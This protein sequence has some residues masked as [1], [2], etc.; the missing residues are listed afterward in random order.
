MAT[1]KDWEAAPT[2]CGP[3]DGKGHKKAGVVASHDPTRMDDLAPGETYIAQAV[4]HRKTCQ[5]ALLVTISEATGTE[6]AF[7]PDQEP[8]GV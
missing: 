4:C 6:A 1:D 2:G 3:D 8:A 7:Y 5:R